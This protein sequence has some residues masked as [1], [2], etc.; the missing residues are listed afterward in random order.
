[1]LWS[2]VAL[3]Y[4]WMHCEAFVVGWLVGRSVDSVLSI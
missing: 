3:L 4:L 2:L 1:V